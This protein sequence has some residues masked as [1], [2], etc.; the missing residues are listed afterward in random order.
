MTLTAPAL[1]NARQVLFLVTGEAKAGII[2]RAFGDGTG[3][4][5]APLPVERIVPV[6][7]QREILVDRAAASRLPAIG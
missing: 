5:E 3:P 1:C 2:A 4:D 7:G 6:D